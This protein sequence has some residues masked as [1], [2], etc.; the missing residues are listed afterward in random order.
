MNEE[1]RW[2]EA[3]RQGDEQAITRLIETYQAVVYG[4][5]CRLLDDAQEAKDAAQETFIKALT[6]L[7]SYDPQ[8]PLRPW[9]LRI[10]TNACIDRLR[11][12]R[13]ELSL[14]GMDEACDA[15]EWMAGRDPPPD[16]VLEERELVL[17]LRRGLRMLPPED[18]VV[19]KLFYWMNYSYEEIAALTGMT[20]PALKSRLFRARRALAQKLM[21]DGHV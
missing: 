7:H 5:C 9:L 11:R 4:L 1:Q 8:R 3:A 18:A 10:A 14:D 19:L 15:W 20:L 21:E 16:Q 6:N 17:A 2:L 12:R 13:G